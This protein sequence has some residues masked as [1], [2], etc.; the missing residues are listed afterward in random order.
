M[1]IIIKSYNRPYYLERCLRSI[2]R[3]VKGV[4]SI[5]S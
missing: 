3:Y 2:E 1:D 5:H 4:Y